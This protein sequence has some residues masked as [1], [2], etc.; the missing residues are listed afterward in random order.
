MGWKEG[1]NKKENGEEFFVQTGSAVISAPPGHPN[2]INSRQNAYAKAFLNAKAKILEFLETTISREVTNN[3]KQGE[4]S[5]EKEAAQKKGE[6]P[7]ETDFQE[8]QRKTLSLVNATLDEKLKEKGVDPESNNTEDQKAVEQTLKEVINSQKFSDI[9][10]SSCIQQLKGIRRMFVTE[11]IKEGKQGEI[12][13]LALYSDKTKALAD[14]VFSDPSMAPKGMLGKPINQQIPNWR[15]RKGVTK[16]LSTFG[17]EMLRDENGEFHLIAYAQ[18]SGKSKSK[19]SQKIAL[20]RANLRA[21][22]EIRTFSQEVAALDKAAE[23]S[24]K[25]KEFADAMQGYESNASFE[26]KLSSI[27]G[28]AKISGIRSIGQW[29]AKHPLTGQTVYGAIVGWSPSNANAAKKIKSQMA[30]Q[31]KSSG[32]AASKKSNNFKNDALKTKG[33]YQGSASGGSS[34]EDF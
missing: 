31:K 16:L 29:G 32:N 30:V 23:D 12:C 6:A 18:S 33:S 10:K 24:E 21:Q 34:D 11:S 2:Y 20:E 17:T 5:W 8:I 9:V 4:F 19:T 3:I 15:T 25:A 7:E 28:P 13:V 26:K 1:R 14:A 27:S 22:A